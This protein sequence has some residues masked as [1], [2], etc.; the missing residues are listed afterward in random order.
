MIKMLTAYT[1]EL[2]DTERAVRDIQEQLDMKNSL[3]K[4]S[5]ALVFC[6]SKFIETGVAEAVCKS[7]PF[8]T[9]GSTSQYFAMPQKAATAS[10]PTMT[11]EFMLAVTV[12]TSDD[13]EFVTG[14]SEPLTEENAEPVIQSLYSKTVASFGEPSLIFSF[15]PTIVGLCGDAMTHALNGVCGDVPVFGAIALDFDTHIR[16]PR[17]I[18]GGASYDDRLTLLLL[19]GPVKPRFYSTF[20][21]EKYIISQDAVVTAAKGSRLISVNNEPAATF[22]RGLGLFQGDD[23]APNP[24]I[25]LIGEDVSGAGGRAIVMQWANTEGEVICGNLVHVGE[26]LNIGMLNADYVTESANT[27]LQDIKNSGEGGE[28]F[29]MCSC[30]LRSIL[31]GGSHEE[32]IELIRK[33]LKNFPGP[34]MFFSSAGEICPRYIEDGKTLNQLFAYALIACRF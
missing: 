7:L 33:E 25:P 32:E 1:S 16:N 24:S 23:Q 22:V 30:L 21:P 13:T 29:I 6:F 26:T 34:F 20:V 28:N 18:Y 12:L 2:N 14:V 27:L 31:L 15:Q 5:A 17:T 10:A 3:L 4:N 19:K 8:D 9:L 11:G